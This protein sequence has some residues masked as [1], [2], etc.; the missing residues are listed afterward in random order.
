MKGKLKFLN[1]WLHI[2]GYEL[3]RYNPRHSEGFQLKRILDKN[4]IDLVIDVG[5]NNGGY[6]TH[7]REI[8]YKGKMISFEPLANAYNKLIDRSKHDQNWNVAERMAIGD[9][10]GETQINVSSNSTSSSILDIKD[11]HVD[12]AP[13]S[14]FVGKETVKIR[15]LDSLI[16]KELPATVS[17]AFLKIDVQGYEKQVLEG[18]KKLLKHI[19]GIQSEMSLVP[20]YE[21]QII[22]D[23]FISRMKKDNFNIHAIFPG[24]MNKKTGQLLQFDGIFIENH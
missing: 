19:K 22:Y 7:L 5:A 9:F 15:T 3:N 2:I 6:G 12:A 24:F 18:A 11:S 17:N 4:N 16:G 20:L 14:N 13:E 8:G 1:K 10:D 21:N 23:E